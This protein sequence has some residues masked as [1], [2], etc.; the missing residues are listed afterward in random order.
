[1]AFS[2]L[3]ATTANED[4]A[5]K[6]SA[7]FVDDLTAQKTAA[8]RSELANNRDVA[9]VAVVHS[10]LLSAFYRYATDHSCLEISTKSFGLEGSLK[11]PQNS[12]A[13]AE[14]DVALEDIKSRLPTNPDALWDWCMDLKPNALLELLAFVAAATVNVVEG[15]STYRNAKHFNHSKQLA[16]ALGTDMRNHF[17]PT[18]D[19]CFAHM[20]LA[21]I[22]ASVAEAKGEEF[23]KGII[24]MKKSEA[25]A[26]AAKAIK[27]TGWLPAPL[28]FEVSSEKRGDVEVFETE[29]TAEITESADIIQFPEAAA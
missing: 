20:N 5:A 15:K 21:T 2:S 12:K 6:L 10:M 23:A 17:E 24:D 19:N 27:G 4:K 8:L 25:A 11:E 16:A 26:F 18:V 1:M 29:A 3:S 7:P 22:Q 28:V 14:L 13:L 9:L